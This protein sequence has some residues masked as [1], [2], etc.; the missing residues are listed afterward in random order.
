MRKSTW[1]LSA[2]SPFVDS[3]LFVVIDIKDPILVYIQAVFTLSADMCCISV[4][5]QMD[6]IKPATLFD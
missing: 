1:F 5:A 4:N 2:F 6:S 3:L